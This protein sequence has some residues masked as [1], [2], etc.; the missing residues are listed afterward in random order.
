MI[1]EENI[2]EGLPEEP[3][4]EEIHKEEELIIPDDNNIFENNI[5]SDKPSGTLVDDLLKGKGIDNAMISIIDEDGTEKE[6]SF[7][8]LTKEE[9]LE[10]LSTNENTSNENLD[11]SEIELINHLRTNNL[12]ME[13]FLAQ[14]RESIIAEIQQNTEVPYT[15][16]AYNDHEL[17][18][19]DLKNK[20]E[21]TDEELQAELEKELQNEELFNK[22]VTKLRA[23]YKQ[24]EDQDKAAKE[25]EFENTKQEQY[26]KFVD[27]MVEIA[28]KIEDFHG[29]YLE[30]NEKQETL[31]YLLDLDESGMSQLSK[32]LND[33]VKL[34]EA[35][36]YL[37]YGKEAFQALE[38]AYEA[39]IA[40]LKK[41]DKPRVVVPNSKKEINSI[42]DLPI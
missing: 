18:L 23:E 37:R 15:I 40:K 41:V 16:D 19:L 22:K 3:V 2:F 21:L 34:Y 10:I 4:T 38:N 29:V 27:N 17:F 25:L 9:Q 11:D 28:T 30:D 31:S 6:V 26:N 24:L 1:D 7:Y 20:Y 39:E 36:W 32:D 33:P 14:Y 5:E 35:A 8:D 13:D 12:S 42:H